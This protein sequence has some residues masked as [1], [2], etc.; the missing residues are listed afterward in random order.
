MP[1]NRVL[2]T[3]YQLELCFIKPVQT[4]FPEDA[5]ARHVVQFGL[6]GTKFSANQRF[7]TLSSVGS[8]AEVQTAQLAGRLVSGKHRAATDVCKHSF[9]AQTMLAWAEPTSPH[10]SYAKE[11]EPC[12][13]P[14]SLNKACFS[15]C[16]QLQDH[17]PS[18]WPEC[19]GCRQPSDRRT[20]A[21]CC[22]ASPGLLW[23]GLSGLRYRGPLQR[24]HVDQPVP[25]HLSLCK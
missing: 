22:A 10:I 24:L 19:D 6:L 7:F 9:S 1:T 13:L 21:P 4:S 23:G 17:L 14:C 2:A 11:G 16:H 25:H 12:H 18:T 20:A 15:P 3:G 8:G 5:D